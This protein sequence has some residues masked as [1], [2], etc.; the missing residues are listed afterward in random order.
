MRIKAFE[1]ATG[2]SRHTVRFYERRGLLP[3]PPRGSDNNY[4]DYDEALVERA[5]MIKLAQRLGFTLAEIGRAIDDYDADTLSTD[6][7]LRFMEDK[8]A[9]I[10]AQMAGLATMRGYL[11]DKVAWMRGGE[12][13]PPPTLATTDG[14]A[15]IAVTC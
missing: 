2:L 1:E 13:G 15:P 12:Q 5:R 10:E 8:I 7:K 14:S 6:D 3:T 9:Q 4:R 11:A